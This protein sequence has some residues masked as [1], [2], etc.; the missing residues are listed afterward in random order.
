MAKS[1]DTD[2]ILKDIEL[3]ELTKIPKKF[4]LLSGWMLLALRETASSRTATTD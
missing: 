4:Q 1:I 2:K 3:L